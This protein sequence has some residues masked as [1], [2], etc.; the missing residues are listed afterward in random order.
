MRGM[1]TKLFVV[2]CSLILAGAPVRA[3]ILELGARYWEMKPSGTASIGA[4]GFEGTEIDIEDD[5]GYGEKEN[6]VGFD[7]A[8]GSG[9]D[10]ALSYLSLDLAARNRI[11]RT[12]R[13]GDTVYR[14]RADVSSSLEAELVRAALRYQLGSHGFRGGL[15]AGVQY[16]DLNAQLSAP[17]YAEAS[18]KTSVFLPVIGAILRFDPA[19]LFR[20]DLGIAGGAWDFDETSVAFWDA[21]ANFRVNINPFF[22]GIGYRHISIDGDESSI[23]LEAD[24]TFKGMQFIGGLVF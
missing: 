12:I 15:L 2:A 1:K 8:L 3:Q 20:I 23:P 10:L 22:I 17:G 13:F 7:A 9:I 11:D 4:D 21:E 14:A 24:L 18:E 5:L 19:P 6:I 16:V